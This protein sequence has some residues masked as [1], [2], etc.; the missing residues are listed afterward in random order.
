VEVA[1]NCGFASQSH[2]ASVF[3]RHVGVTPS[4]FERVSRTLADIAK[5][6]LL[7]H[8]RPS[9]NRYSIE[10]RCRYIVAERPAVLRLIASVNLVGS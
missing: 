7:T 1:L 3:Q 8:K 6:T 5:A 4:R 10:Q 2:F 9:A